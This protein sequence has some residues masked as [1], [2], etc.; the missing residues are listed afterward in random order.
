MDRLV[1]RLFAMSHCHVIL[2]EDVD[3]GTA[4]DIPTTET[5]NGNSVNGM[6]SL[7]LKPYN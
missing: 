5:S 3:D 4:E 2:E 6:L 7:G 1:L